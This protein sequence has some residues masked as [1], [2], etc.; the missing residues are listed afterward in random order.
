VSVIGQRI[1]IE[2][3]E[4]STSGDTV[5]QA[6]IALNAESAAMLLSW[7]GDRVERSFIIRGE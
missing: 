2:V 3:N 5:T 7:L 4:S 1:Y 6:T